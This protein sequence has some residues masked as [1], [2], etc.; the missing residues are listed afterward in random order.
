MHVFS[1]RSTLKNNSFLLLYA[2]RR[3]Y[4]AALPLLHTEPVRGEKQVGRQEEGEVGERGGSDP[5]FPESFRRM[6]SPTSLSPC[7]T[8]SF[9]E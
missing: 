3:K 8:F 4:S 1:L 6:S 9:K 2:S 7:Q 5:Y